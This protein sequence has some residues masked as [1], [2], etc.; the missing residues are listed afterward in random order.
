[1]ENQSSIIYYEMSTMLASAPYQ[2]LE[3]RAKDEIECLKA[4][5]K[6]SNDP[7]FVLA[8]VKKIEGIEWFTNEASEIIAQELDRAN[9][10]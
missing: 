5:I 8:C 10:Q 6:T 2:E 7:V 9:N 1:M 3:R 4:N